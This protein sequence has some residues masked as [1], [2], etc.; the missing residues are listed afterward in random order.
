[1][2]MMVAERLLFLDVDGVLNPWRATNLYGDWRKMPLDPAEPRRH[3]FWVSADL[4]R[5]LNSL[6]ADGVRIVWAT[7]WIN[8]PTKLAAYAGLF[9]IPD[10]P[11][12]LDAVTSDERRAESGKLAALQRWLAEHAIDITTARI[13]WVDDDL[14]QK[15]LEWAAAS[16]VTAVRPLP[17]A[18]LA[19]RNLRVTI[20]A[21]LSPV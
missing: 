16:G 21:G 20:E 11:D 3:R 14:S 4:G 2:V 12:R 5:W 1:M 9:G 15:E 7:S 17:S 8:H 13:A 19:D 18:G 6:L 10:L